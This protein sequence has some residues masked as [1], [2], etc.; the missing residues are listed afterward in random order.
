MSMGVASL[1]ASVT[2]PLAERLW[3]VGGTSALKF[4]SCPVALDKDL[5][6]YRYL[7]NEPAHGRHQ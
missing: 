1:N 2:W 5:T 6:R 3:E 4:A 7:V